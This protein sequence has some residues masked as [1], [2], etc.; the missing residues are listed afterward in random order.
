MCCLENVTNSNRLTSSDLQHKTCWRNEVQS[1][2]LREAMYRIYII[3]TNIGTICMDIG[4]TIGTQFL[5]VAFV[6]ESPHTHQ[7]YILPRRSVKILK[8]SIQIASKH[9]A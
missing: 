6:E 3:I 9:R 1:I 7:D 4:L 2:F 5:M 8:K